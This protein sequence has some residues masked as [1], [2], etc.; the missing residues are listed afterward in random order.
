[1][2]PTGLGQEHQ[3]ERRIHRDVERLEAA[4]AIH[5]E[6]RPQP[7]DEPDLLRVLL[8]LGGELDRTLDAKVLA[9]QAEG[10]GIVRPR[11]AID[12]TPETP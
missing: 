12:L 9:V 3:I 6:R 1:M 5:L 2:R 4:A 10:G 7:A 11:D 8:Q